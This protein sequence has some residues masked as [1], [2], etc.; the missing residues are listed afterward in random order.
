M[1]GYL[2]IEDFLIRR[3]V[4]PGSISCI[5]DIEA[6]DLSR[7]T[8]TT[9]EYLSGKNIEANDFSTTEGRK[10]ARLKHHLASRTKVLTALIIPMYVA[11]VWLMIML[12]LP[13]FNIKVFSERMQILLLS[14]LTSDL[15]GL[16]YV[17][18][19]NLFP[20]KPEFWE[21]E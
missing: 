2:S 12:S 5:D 19:R 20:Q 1:A 7:S 4:Y 10:S 13:A 15:I 8:I 6:T 18:T 9:E 16:C 17:V 21:D 11:P 14:A 3:G